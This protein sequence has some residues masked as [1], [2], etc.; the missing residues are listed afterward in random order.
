[1]KQLTTEQAIAFHNSGAWKAMS[2]KE[3]AV[4][5]MQQDKLCMPFGE[6]HKA[7]EETLDRPVWTHEFGLNSDGIRAELEGKAKAPTFAEILAMLP[8]C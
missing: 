5:Q 8:E 1:M 2:A 6:F 7:V 4:F 3:R